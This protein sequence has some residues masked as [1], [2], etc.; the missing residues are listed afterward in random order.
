MIVTLITDFGTADHYAAVMKGVILSRAPKARIVDISHHIPPQH[1]EQAAFLLHM[2]WRH[3]PAGT[4]HTVVVDPGVGTER[5]VLAAQAEEHLFLAPDNGILSYILHACPDLC[6]HSVENR[7]LFPPGISS[8]FH[9]R[10]IFAPLAAFL[11]L[12]GAI[13]DTGPLFDAV[14]RGKVPL[15]DAVGNSI[16]GE[17]VYIDAFGNC[18]T[19]IPAAMMEGKTFISAECNSHT[20]HRLSNTYADAESGRGVMLSGSHGYL[21]ISLRNGSAAD[22]WRIR[23]GN[24]VSIHFQ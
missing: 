12:G 17:V 7:E 24:S 6:I 15:P 22:T 16:R 20:I 23:T 11:A 1:V 9:G 4:V 19:N 8:V 13:A 10:D 2:S 3:F 5:R 18:I 14:E 21:E